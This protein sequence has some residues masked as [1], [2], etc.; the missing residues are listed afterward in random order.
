V[1]GSLVEVTVPDR[2]STRAAPRTTVASP[3]GSAVLIAPGGMAPGPVTGGVAAEAAGGASPGSISI[4]PSATPR[5]RCS[6]NSHETTAPSG[7][8]RAE[9]VND[10]FREGATVG[11]T[12]GGRPTMASL[13]CS[14]PLLVS[15]ATIRSALAGPGA[16][17][18]PMSNVPET[19]SGLSASLLCQTGLPSPR[20]RASIPPPGLI[21]YASRRSGSTMTPGL[22]WK[23]GTAPTLFHGMSS[24]HAPRPRV[25]ARRT[26]LAGL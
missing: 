9:A 20:S 17:A 18:W 4:G 19:V 7:S 21:T 1:T 2:G 8:A 22:S 14:P 24:V 23:L 10:W 13:T 6:T 5:A 25:A 12:P 16:S 11:W 15:R 3:P 26:R